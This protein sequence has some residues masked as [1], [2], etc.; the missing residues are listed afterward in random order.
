MLQNTE[1]HKSIRGN[2]R[3]YIGKK[4]VKKP[5]SFS[6]I[7]GALRYL[8]SFAQFK[9]HEKQPWRSV[10]FSKVAGFSATLLK[11]TLLHGYFSRFL[12][13]TNATKSR[14][15]SQLRKT[16]DFHLHPKV[17]F[18]KTLTSHIVLFVPLLSRVPFSHRL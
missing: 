7:S 13:C 9:K 14:K 15:A 11:V 17:L 4:W 5:F 1:K 2:Q 6:L 10:T 12:N 18:D 8:V 16:I 3:G